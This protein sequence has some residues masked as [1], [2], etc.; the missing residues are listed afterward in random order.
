MLLFCKK[1]LPGRL[2]SSL[3]KWL[4]EDQIINAEQDRFSWQKRLFNYNM[5]EN[6]LS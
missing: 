2:N 6:K 1:K 3:K 4:Y 5:K